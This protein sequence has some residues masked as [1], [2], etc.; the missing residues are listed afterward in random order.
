MR[1]G[2]GFQMFKLPMV[3]VNL[4]TVTVVGPGLRPGSRF[5]FG[6][7]IRHT[8]SLSIGCGPGA[9][10]PP[11]QDPRGPCRRGG[12]ESGPSRGLPATSQ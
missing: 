7:R 5:K 3:R 2:M 8:V 4:V 10:G 9:A 1:T 11:R 6:G 12:S